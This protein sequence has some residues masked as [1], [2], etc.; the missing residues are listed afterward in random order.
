MF[1]SSFLYIVISRHSR[2]VCP[3]RF[4]H[5]Y[6]LHAMRHACIILPNKISI[7]TQR[8]NVV[9][10]VVEWHKNSINTEYIGCGWQ[11]GT[12]SEFISV[13]FTFAQQKKEMK[14][15]R[16]KRNKNNGNGEF[17]L[18]FRSRCRTFFV[19]CTIRSSQYFSIHYIFLFL[20]S[21]STI[22]M[23]FYCDNFRITWRTLELL[24]LQNDKIQ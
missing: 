21:L 9:V 11:F 22:L 10:V 6:Y 5:R 4:F 19:H 24:A 1:F 7:N 13:Y 3:W 16:K 17:R 20:F 23:A 14:K 8:M 15:K 18:I 12:A 2:A